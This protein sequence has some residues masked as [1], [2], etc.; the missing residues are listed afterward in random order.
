MFDT[1]LF[2]HKKNINDK[3]SFIF[4]MDKKFPPMLHAKNDNYLLALQV[5]IIKQ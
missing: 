4:E 1:K 3:I 5:M 2:K